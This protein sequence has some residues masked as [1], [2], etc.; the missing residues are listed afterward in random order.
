MLA[1]RLSEYYDVLLLESGGTPPPGTSVP[2]Y[3]GAVGQHP[4]INY[5]FDSVPQTNASLCCDGVI[6]LI[7]NFLFRSIPLLN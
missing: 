6:Q 5:F 2:Y 7:N 3:I 4:S 1:G